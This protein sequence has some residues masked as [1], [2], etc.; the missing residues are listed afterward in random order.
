M[1][2][3]FDHRTESITCKAKNRVR[4]AESV[5]VDVNVVIRFSDVDK[6]KTD[7]PDL[8]G[9]V[10]GRTETGFRTNVIAIVINHG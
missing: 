3:A 1:S 10:F 2:T 6:G 4:K 7:F 5:F 8:I 9:V